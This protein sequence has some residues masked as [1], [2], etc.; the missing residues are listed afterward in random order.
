MSVAPNIRAEEPPQSERE[1]R[2]RLRTGAGFTPITD[3]RRFLA[4]PSSHDAD[5]RGGVAF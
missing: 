4:A 5:R 3:T 2:G 1:A